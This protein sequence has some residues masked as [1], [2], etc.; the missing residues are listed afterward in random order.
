MLVMGTLYP[1]LT[2]GDDGLPVPQA[3]KGIIDLKGYDF[4]G[5]GPL[6]LAGEWGFYWDTVASSG[7]AGRLMS[8]SPNHYVQVPSYWDELEH[9]DSGITANGVATYTLKVLKDS[10]RESGDLALKFLNI[11]PNAA[12]YLNGRHV[13]EF[14]NVD[15][16]PALSRSGNRIFMIPIPDSENVLELVISISNFHNVNGGLNRPIQIGLYNDILTTRERLLSADAL[17]LG[18]LML[19]GLYQLSLFLLDRKRKAP[20]FMAILCVLAFFFSGFKNEMVLLSLFPG[21]DGEVRTKF[22]Y[23]A[24]T[25][26]APTFIL[27]A[28]NLYPAHF[29]KSL[30]WIPLVFALLFSAVILFTPKSFYTLFILPLEIMVF[31]S[32]VYTIVM[33]VIGFSRSKDKRILYYLSGLAFLLASIVFS[34]VDNELSIVFQSAAGVFFVFILYQAFLQAYIFSSAFSEID[35]LS[36]KNSRLEKRNVELF[37]LTYIDS[38]TETCNRRLMDDFLT[39][40]WRIN[41][42]NERSVGMILID[43]DDFKYYNEFYGH[44]Q[45]DVCLIKVCDLL[46]DELSKHGQYTLARYGG[47]EFAVIVSDMDEMTLFR[48]AEGLRM[49]V[50]AGGIE[51][52]TSRASDVVTI[53]IG[54]AC[55]VPSQESEPESLLDAADKALHRAKKNGRN[56]TELYNSEIQE[57]TWVPKLV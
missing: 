34:V 22:I 20:A 10:S 2:G 23:L 42:F 18:G 30:N 44:R 54:S 36:Q 37:S 31:V 1:A 35:N 14:G 50:E 6:T 43:I 41:T 17:F 7:T 11:T 52:R 15:R 3:R 32:A 4:S 29:R 47:E 38:L 9:E 46:R 51:H 25:L 8:E 26:S 24:L 39:S 48:T 49:A 27:Y 21:W 40:C 12:I 13:A 55:L 56:R 19:M 16:D 28:Y 45:G 33:L 5:E 53:S 57:S